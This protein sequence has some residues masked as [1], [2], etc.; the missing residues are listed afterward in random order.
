MSTRLH[1]LI[2]DQKGLAAIRS[3]G[4]CT[5]TTTPR[6]W[7][8]TPPARTPSCRRWSARRAGDA[9]PVSRRAGRR[10]TSSTRPS[11]RFVADI[12]ACYDDL[13]GL[14]RAGSAAPRTVHAGRPAGE[15]GPRA[16][17]GSPRATSGR[18]RA[19]SDPT[20]AAVGGS[21]RSARSARSW[22]QAGR[23][24]SSASFARLG[25]RAGAGTAAQGPRD[26][27]LPD[28]GRRHGRWAKW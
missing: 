10:R 8:S 21:R 25:R 2:C 27:N 18:S 4:R 17:P 11:R 6:C 3:P 14:A 9:G 28:V 23:G 13:D 16:G 7:R 5:R 24:R 20:R 26:P 19:G 15:A 22:P 12:E 1:Y